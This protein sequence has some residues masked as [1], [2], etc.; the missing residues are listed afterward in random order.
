MD[1]EIIVP[2][3]EDKPDF[4]AIMACF[5]SSKTEEERKMLKEM[6]MDHAFLIFGDFP[7]G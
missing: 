6:Y 3:E 1:G 2:G 5:L 7:I 4:E